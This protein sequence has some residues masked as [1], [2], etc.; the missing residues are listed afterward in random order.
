MELDLS[1]LQPLPSPALAPC[2]QGPVLACENEISIDHTEYFRWNTPEAFRMIQD[3]SHQLQ[4]QQNQ[5]NIS[6]NLARI[7]NDEHSRLPNAKL[8][9]VHPATLVEILK[10]ETEMRELAPNRD[11]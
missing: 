3:Q 1:S 4:L 9:D 2:Y 6:P 10:L 7:M 8:D 5:H 11:T